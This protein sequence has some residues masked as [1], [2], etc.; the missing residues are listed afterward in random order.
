MF[1]GGDKAAKV[2]YKN[3][4]NL[5]TNNAALEDLCTSLATCDFITVDTEFLRE[6]TYWPKLC[7][8][9]TA[10]DG[11][12]GMIDPLAD[13]LDLKPFY[14][15]LVNPNVTKVMHGCRQDIEI[16]HKQAGII[17]T[18]VIDTQIAAMVCGFGDA[19][20]YE[21]LIRKTTGGK[22]DKD[23]RFTDWGRRPLSEKQLTYARADV[24]HLRDAYRYLDG[25]LT[26]NG[27]GNWL[28]EEMDK[29]LN[30]ETYEQNPEHAWKRLKFQDRRPHVMGVFIEVAKWRDATAQNRDVP[31]NRVLKDDA[32]RE[33]A[34]QAPRHKQAIAKLRAVPKGFENSRYADEL[35]AAISRGRTRDKDS[36]PDLAPPVANRPGIGPLVELLKVLLKQR[37]ED[38]GVAPKLI[39]NVSD[40]ERIASDDDPDVPALHGWRRE[41]FGDYAM[42]LKEGRLALA[43][44]NN[45]VV[46]ISRD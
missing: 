12:E 14:D 37:S 3:A 30:P 22:V 7:L 15:L 31:R 28:D 23:S 43:S 25:E 10:G 44:E 40:L 27:R 6:S 41:I 20:G 9:Q 26:Q 19:V 11:F 39:A 45:S 33:L 18:P 36:L 24:T 16:F 42:A 1:S 2:L 46:L 4:M 35:L 17:P 21:T 8:I 13:G 34:I 29:L 38:S 32:I 5:V